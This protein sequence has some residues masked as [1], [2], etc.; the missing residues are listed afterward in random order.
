MYEQMGRKLN[1]TSAKIPA[2]V[3]QSS[4]GLNLQK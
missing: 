1:V 2:A 3:I 4:A